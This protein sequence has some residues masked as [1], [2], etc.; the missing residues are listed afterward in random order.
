MTAPT[1]A[2]LNRARRHCLLAAVGSTPTPVEIPPEAA[3]YDW[4]DPHYFNEDQRNRLAAIMSQV[5]AVLSERCAHFFNSEF[6]VVPA[7]ITQHFA[8]DVGRHVN[9]ERG[10]SLTFGPAQKPPCGFLGIG[11]DV[12]MDWVT[13][14]LGDSESDQD[15][16]RP[17]SSLEE[18]LLLD[19]AGAMAEAFLDSLKPHQDLKPAGQVTQGAAVSFEPTD[20]ICRIVFRIGQ[21]EADAPSEVTFIVSGPTLSPVVGKS[22]QAKTTLSPEELTRLLMEHVQQMP[23]VISARLGSTRLSFDEVLD[24]APGDILL[25]DKPLDEPVDLIIRNQ[26]VFRGRPA[27][28]DGQ[29]AVFITERATSPDVR[30]DA[31]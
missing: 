8:N 5:A 29:Y 23:V 9:V 13:R 19:L 31:K 20:P 22:I 30:R 17:L 4:R 3:L 27:Q 18:S 6:K 14:L 12:A 2:N 24:L 16:N 28:S 10:F 21:A 11:A 1:G 15:P 26:T 7:S 25:I